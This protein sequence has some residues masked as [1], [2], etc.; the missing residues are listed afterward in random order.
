MKASVNVLCT[1]S[2]YSVH[3]RKWTK[4]LN[5]NLQFDPGTYVIF[6]LLYWVL[7]QREK[8]ESAGELSGV[9]WTY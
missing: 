2:L 6:D 7:T 4:L 8:G 5:I 9:S 3:F 1:P